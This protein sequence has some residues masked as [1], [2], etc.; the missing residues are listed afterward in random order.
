MNIIIADVLII[1]GAIFCIISAYGCYKFPTYSLSVHAAGVGD[2]LGAIL[3]LTGV[4]IK[5][6][7]INSLKIMMILFIL[8]IANPTATFALS[9]IAYKPK[10]GK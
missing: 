10:R 7:N 4:A 6:C 2:N 1:L 5:F 8:F 3:C 9:R